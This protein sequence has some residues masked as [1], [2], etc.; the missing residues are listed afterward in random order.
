MTYEI[1]LL[2]ASNPYLKRYLREN[3]K[4]YKNLLR[5][6][7]FIHELVNLM[8]KEYKLTFHDRLDKIG[9]DIGIL[10]SVMDVLR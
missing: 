6:P 5:N 8:K 2:L 10:N 7:L 4:F 3:S 9:N 1:Q